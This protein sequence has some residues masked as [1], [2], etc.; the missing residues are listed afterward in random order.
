MEALST[1]ED[2]SWNQANNEEKSEAFEFAVAVGGA[3]AG[4]LRDQDEDYECV[5][6]VLVRISHF[7]GNCWS[8]KE[9]R[10]WNF[11]MV[12]PLSKLLRAAPNLER[13]LPEHSV[14]LWGI[15]PAGQGD[16]LLTLQETGLDRI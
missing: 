13:A 8:F 5:N 3:Q 11:E 7:P 2:S 6:S 15:V 1:G 4:G 9:R 12:W 10:S 16:D 14:L